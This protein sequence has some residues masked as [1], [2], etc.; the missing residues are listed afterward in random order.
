MAQCF[1]GINPCLGI[2]GEDAG[3]QVDQLRLWLIFMQDCLPGCW[4][5]GWQVVPCVFFL[6]V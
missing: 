5:D 4:A 1:K 3:Y 6:L 2:V